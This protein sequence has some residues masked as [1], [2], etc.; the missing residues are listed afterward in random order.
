MKLYNMM[1]PQVIVYVATVT[2]SCC[3]AGHYGNI[4]YNRHTITVIIII[5]TLFISRLHMQCMQHSPPT[6]PYYHS[7]TLKQ[8]HCYS[9]DNIG[10]RHT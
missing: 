10:F 1:K 2:V 4:S 5:M 8:V 7:D 6:P 3:H 9:I